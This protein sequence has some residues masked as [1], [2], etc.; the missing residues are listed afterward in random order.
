MAEVVQ[1]ITS[2]GVYFNVAENIARLSPKLVVLLE[3]PNRPD[4]IELLMVNSNVLKLVLDW[5]AHHK[6]NTSLKNPANSK[7]DY[8]KATK[9]PNSK[10]DSWDQKFLSELDPGTLFELVMVIK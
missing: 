9:D 7:D 10:N 3:T 4:I 8:W 1:I 6:Y 2:D 5:L